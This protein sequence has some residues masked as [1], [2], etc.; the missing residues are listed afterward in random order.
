[1]LGAEVE[2]LQ[3]P[4][5]LRVCEARQTSASKICSGVVLTNGTLPSRCSF[6]SYGPSAPFRH[7]RKRRTHL[8][9]PFDFGDEVLAAEL[10]IL[11]IQ[12]LSAERRRRV[13]IVLALKNAEDHLICGG[14]APSEVGLAQTTAVGEADARLLDAGEFS[15]TR[16]GAGG[17]ERSSVCRRSSLEP[18]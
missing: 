18:K 14:E 16:R 6:W 7:E 3:S 15:G 4:T 5:T 11:G 9:L 12:L 10:A 1:M 13:A 8:A 2:I 17:A